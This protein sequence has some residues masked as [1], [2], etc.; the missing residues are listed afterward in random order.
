MARKAIT[1]GG[2]ALVGRRRAAHL[3]LEPDLTA[4]VHQTMPE[5]EEDRQKNLIL[6]FCHSSRLDTNDHK[7]LC[8]ILSIF[9]Q[10]IST[11][12]LFQNVLLFGFPLILERH[13]N[14]IFST[15]LFSSAAPGT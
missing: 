12:S 8:A 3:E 6:Y 9:L 15:S 10:R 7:Y 14:S 4:Q 2:L 13:M 11:K 5:A 1:Y